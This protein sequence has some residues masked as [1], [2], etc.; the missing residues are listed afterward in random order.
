[1]I[2]SMANGA[3]ESASLSFSITAIGH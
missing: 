2:T 3:L 1:V